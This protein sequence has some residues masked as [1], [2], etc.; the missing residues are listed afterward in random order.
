MISTRVHGVR[1]L[2]VH[3]DTGFEPL[4]DDLRTLLLGCAC[5]INNLF[6]R[7]Q[8]VDGVLRILAARGIVPAALRVILFISLIDHIRLVLP[9]CL[10]RLFYF[11][12]SKDYRFEAYF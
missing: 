4:A 5:S 11:L 10:T 8:P 3:Y 9:A 6:T 1:L 12:Y 7:V 2:A